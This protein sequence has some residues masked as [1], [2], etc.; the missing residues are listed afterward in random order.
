M[1]DLNI[2]YNG[3]WVEADP[4]ADPLNW[5]RT[6]VAQRWTE[7]GLPADPELTS[8]VAENM[9]DI[10]GTAFEQDPAPLMLFLLYPMANVSVLAAVAVR[11]EPCDQ[12]SLEQLADEIRLPD[13][14]LEQPVDQGTVDTPAGPALRLIQRYR[15]PI[16]PGIEQVQ[17]LIAHAWIIHD[18]DGPRLVTIAASFTDLV[19]AVEWRPA[20]DEL[21]QSL[22]VHP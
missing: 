22:Q 1:T 8:A 16:E 21:A 10:I 2:N 5:A 11:T 3:L 7:E 17:E 13:P 6:T 18:G 4:D 20:I 19:N 14:M 9:A 12:I 15:A